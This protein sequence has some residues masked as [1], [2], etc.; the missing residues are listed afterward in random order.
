MSCVT[1]EMVVLRP[2]VE[3]FAATHIVDMPTES[4]VRAQLPLDALSQTPKTSAYTAPHFHH[5]HALAESS[6]RKQS[7]HAQEEHDRERWL[8]DPKYKDDNLD[9]VEPFHVGPRN[10]VGKNLAWHEL[11]LFLATTYTFFDLELTE[12]SQNWFADNRVFTVW[13]KPPLWCRVKAAGKT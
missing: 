2:V 11:R 4:I 10:C 12:K 13:E 3:L 8:G 7:C 1:A 6:E 5:L 9:A